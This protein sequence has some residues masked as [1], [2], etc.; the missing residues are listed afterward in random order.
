MDAIPPPP[1]ARWRRLAVTMLYV[2]LA[3]RRLPRPA[4]VA[5]WLPVL[6]AAQA[7]GVR[8]LPWM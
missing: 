7:L 6:W 4:R 8:L 2:D 3:Y 1:G 5:L